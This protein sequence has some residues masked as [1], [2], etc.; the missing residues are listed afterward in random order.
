M[1]GSSDEQDVPRRRA[2]RRRTTDPR[3]GREDRE[4]RV[5]RRTTRREVSAPKP[6]IDTNAVIESRKAPTPL[7]AEKEGQSQRR[8]KFVVTMVILLVG[9]GASAAVGLSDSGQID[10]Q[11]TIEARNER[12]RNNQ[13]DERDTMISNVEIPVQDTNS[14]G[15]ADG[16]LLGRGTGGHNPAPVVE[17]VATT[18]ATSTDMTASSTD[19]VASSTDDGTGAEEEVAPQENEVTQ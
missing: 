8:K 3:E 13:A 10:V 5:S 12:I 4:P 16:G 18:T 9:I 15:K 14:V 7:A 6:E 19:A 11:Q 1:P 17:E 2:P